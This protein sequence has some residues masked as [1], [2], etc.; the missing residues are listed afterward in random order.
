MVGHRKAAAAA[1]CG[2]CACAPSIDPQRVPPVV[3]ARGRAVCVYAPACFMLALPCCAYVCTQVCT[4]TYA[5][6]H[7]C[8]SHDYCPLNYLVH[9]ARSLARPLAPARAS[10]TPPTQRPSNPRPCSSSSSS[11][12]S[13]RMYATGA[14]TNALALAAPSQATAAA[15]AIRMCAPPPLLYLSISL[16][17]SPA[18]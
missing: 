4:H 5:Y 7:T 9:A 2:R 12:C 17:P 3:R 1:A 10:T 11:S 14:R 8:T 18:R 6:T 16:Y 15:A 13:L